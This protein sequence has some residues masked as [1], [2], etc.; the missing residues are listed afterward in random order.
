MGKRH[1]LAEVNV[2]NP[3]GTMNEN[4]G[5]YR[6]M[7]RYE[8]RK[9]LL[10]DLERDGLLEKIETHQFALGECHRCGTPIEPYLSEQWFVSMKERRLGFGRSE[11]G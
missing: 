3:D 4:A 1:E 2:M 6:G 9:K 7:E 11:R 8:C 10:E 5:P